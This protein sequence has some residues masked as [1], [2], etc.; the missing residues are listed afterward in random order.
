VGVGPTA[1]N[2]VAMPSQQRGRL[3]PATD[4]RPG[5]AAA[6]RA[7]PAPRGQPSPSGVGPPAG[8]AP[9]P[10]AATPA[11][12]RSWSLRAAPAAPA[13]PAAGRRSNRAVVAPSTDQLRQRLS[14]RNRSSEPT[15]DLLAPTGPGDQGPAGRPGRPRK[16][17]TKLHCDKGYDYPRYRQALRRRGFTSR[18]ARHGVEDGRRLGRHRWVIERSLAW[19]VGYRRLQVRY[20]RRADLLRGLVYL[21]CALICL[22]GP[23]SQGHVRVA[24]SALVQLPDED[25]DPPQRRADGQHLPVKAE[26]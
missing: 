21:A 11:A 9:Q 23:L 13:I 1:L 25:A 15:V 4:A 10:R 3:A 7:R 8:G 2:Q 22:I 20:E 16:R 14:R 5:G 24:A 12:P 6:A 18:I 26:Q 17:P 19:L